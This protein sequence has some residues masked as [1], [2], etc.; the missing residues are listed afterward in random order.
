MIEDPFQEGSLVTVAFKVW[1][2]VNV[3][4]RFI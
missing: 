1:L 4:R 3:F 2:H